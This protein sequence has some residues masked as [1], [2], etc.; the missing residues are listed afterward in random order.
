MSKF[1]LKKGT[2]HDRAADEQVAHVHVPG[3]AYNVADPVTKL[4]HTIGGGF[5]NEPKYYDT[6][7]SYADFMAELLATGKIASKIVDEKGLTEQAREV[8]ETST[9][10]ANSESPEDLLIIAAWAR[11]TENGLRL[12]T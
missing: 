6:N 2:V 1:G 8:L 10:V 4:I 5:F 11:D 9:A 3:K 7:R 12:R